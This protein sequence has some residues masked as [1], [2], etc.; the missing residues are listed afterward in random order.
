MEPEGSLPGHKNQ[1]SRVPHKYDCS[2]LRNIPYSLPQET[3]YMKT[4]HFTL[5]VR[6]VRNPIVTSRMQSSGRNR[7]YPILYLK[8]QGL[9]GFQIR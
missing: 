4:H 5:C 8:T 6:T 1:I 2:T 7:I 9:I 3:N